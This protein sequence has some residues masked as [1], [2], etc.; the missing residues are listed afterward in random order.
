MFSNE[1]AIFG[2]EIPLQHEI[3]AFAASL[4]NYQT[5]FDTLIQ[6]SLSIFFLFITIH[7]ERV[8]L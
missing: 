8:A 4:P 2:T 1:L 5:S 3:I 6:S 7:I